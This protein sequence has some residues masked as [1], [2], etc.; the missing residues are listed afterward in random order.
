MAN[1]ETGTTSSHD[2]DVVVIGGGP[3]GSTAAT[4]LSMWG[5]R[6]LLLERDFFPRHHVGESLLPGTEHVLKRLGVYDEVNRAGFIPKYGASYVW[7]R[8]RK[9]WTIYFPEVSRR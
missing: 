9:P 3:G 7:G 4:L 6:V 2:Y 1:F 5:R 8:S